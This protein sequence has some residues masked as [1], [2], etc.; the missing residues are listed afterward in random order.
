M[1]L[2][3]IIN[4]IKC[5]LSGWF[6]RLGFRFVQGHCPCGNIHIYHS[7]FRSKFL[8]T[9]SHVITQVHLWYP[10]A[11]SSF[12]IGRQRTITLTHSDFFSCRVHTKKNTAWKFHSMQGAFVIIIFVSTRNNEY[13]KLRVKTTPVMERAITCTNH[14]ECDGVCHCD[15]CC[16]TNDGRKHRPRGCPATRS[17]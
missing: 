9:S 13:H 14:F 3:P 5:K 15:V 6:I 8:K 17:Y 2:L 12:D 7:K 1:S 11:I 4:S 16:C 10:S